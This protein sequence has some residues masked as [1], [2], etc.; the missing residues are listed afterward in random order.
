MKIVSSKPTITR[1]DLEGVLECL[2][3]DELTTGNP[4]KAFENSI[5]EPQIYKD[6]KGGQ[7]KWLNYPKKKKKLKMHY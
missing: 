5:S 3:N 1:K 6:V 7:R 4:V 2:I